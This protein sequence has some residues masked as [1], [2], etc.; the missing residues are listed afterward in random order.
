MN[1]AQTGLIWFANMMMQIP[2]YQP[3]WTPEFCVKEALEYRDMLKEYLLK[4]CDF[5]KM[6]IEELQSLG[7][8]WWDDN[9]SLLLCPMWLANT[10][11]P[12]KDHDHRN[13]IIAFGF[14]VEDGN[15]LFD[16]HKSILD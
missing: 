10:L 6:S 2:E 12:D 3:N 16:I 1:K 8:A 9:K 13:G 7:F 14:K 11:F 15:V 5:S 4:E